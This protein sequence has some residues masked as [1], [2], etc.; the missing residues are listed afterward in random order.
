MTTPAGVIEAADEAGHESADPY[1][2]VIRSEE[3][4]QDELG[5]LL[6][7]VLNEL[8]DEGVDRLPA[9]LISYEPPE[10]DDE[11]RQGR[12]DRVRVP[13]TDVAPW[14]RICALRIKAPGVPQTLYGTGW[15]A[16][17]RTV[18][19]AGHCVYLKK[20]QRWAASIEVIPG[21][22]GRIAPFGRITSSRF[23]SV[24]GWRDLAGRR[25]RN[26]DYGAILLPEP[27]TKDPGAFDFAAEE[28]ATL[29]RM[30][31]NL[32]GYPTD[33]PPGAGGTG[34]FFHARPFS[35][36]GPTRLRYLI[37]THSGQSGSPVW[38]LRHGSRTVVG[39]HTAG[40]Y[41]GNSATRI[42]APVAANLAAWRSEG[43]A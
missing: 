14:S 19:T 29:A 37:D 2:A 6:D 7:A 3:A 5:G 27:F 23:R 9:H 24:A 28:D 40:Y 43:M 12:D 33:R 39:I 15:L 20:L 10:G 31:A 22:D 11:I 32:A 18:I 30:P 42:T 16:G 38:R 13:S 8:L 35:D 41:L 1:H 4:E 25:R 36:V 17:P 34:L 26:Y 21:L